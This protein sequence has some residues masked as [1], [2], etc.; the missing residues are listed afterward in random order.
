MLQTLL[1]PLTQELNASKAW[2]TLDKYKCLLS[3]FS[4]GLLM[5]LCTG[6]YLFSER[7]LICPTKHLIPLYPSPQTVL[8]EGCRS[9]FVCISEGIALELLLM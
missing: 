4:V 3:W 7:V 6:L 5:V 1:I 9:Q 8:E 2:P